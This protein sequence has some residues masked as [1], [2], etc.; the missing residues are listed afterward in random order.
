MSHTP[1]A[2]PR[3]ANTSRQ[4][5]SSTP[6]ASLRAARVV[7]HILYG[8]LLACVYRVLSRHTQ[9]RIVRHW[10]HALLD[11][12]NI[13]VE[14]YG[15][16]VPAATRGVLFVANHISWLD[17]VAMNAAL[18]SFFVAK[19]EV[20][21]WPLL[22][23]M[24]RRIDTLFIQRDT[25]RDTTRISL[26]LSGLLERGE[27]V[28]VF[29][30]ATTTDGMQ[31]KHFHSSLLQSAV[32]IEAPVCPLT[33]RYHDGKG[34]ANLDAAFTGDMGFVQSLWKVLRSPSLHITLAY[35]PLLDSTDKTRRALAAEAH[36]AI[37]QTLCLLAENRFQSMPDATPKKPWHAI[38]TSASP[39]YALLLS[40]MLE[41]KEKRHHDA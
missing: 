32:E 35:L 6:R 27:R 33:I 29:P 16:Q 30:E 17:V 19:S 21:N 12:L 39:S 1:D 41:T 5:V 31:V 23:W 13:G 38:R 28:S 18:P 8:L 36:E 3:P 25:R 2:L 24:C 4:P 10:A 40:P 14:T 37:Q 11:I 26:A 34:N 9:L 20:G 7:F 22:G 15:I